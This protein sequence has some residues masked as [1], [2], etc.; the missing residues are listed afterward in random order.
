[1]RTHERV[2]QARRRDGGT[3]A[4]KCTSIPYKPRAPLQRRC[5]AVKYKIARLGRPRTAYSLAHLSPHYLLCLEETRF[6]RTE[7][8]S[9]LVLFSVSFFLISIFFWCL[10]SSRVFLCPPLISFYSLSFI[11][12]CQ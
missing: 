6:A 12:A 10:C 7:A 8:A 5:S 3:T 2:N 4:C 1:M 11:A 9:C